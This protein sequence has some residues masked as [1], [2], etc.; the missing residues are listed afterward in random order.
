MLPRVVYYQPAARGAAK[1]FYGPRNT[2]KGTEFSEPE[3]GRLL[4]SGQ[5]ALVFHSRVMAEVHERTELATSCAK[6]IQ[7]LRAVL[8]AQL[9]NGLDFENYF[10]VADKI[11]VKC[12][13]PICGRGIAMFA[14]AST[15]MEFVEIRI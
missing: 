9:R 6:I 4:A 12:F 7:D 14:V 5:E 15:K 3:M 8:I 1:V 2:R 13:K 11:R 10:S